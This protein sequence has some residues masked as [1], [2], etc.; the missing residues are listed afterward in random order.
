MEKLHYE[1]SYL[2]EI[3]SIISGNVKAARAR[4]GITQK[5]LAERCGVTIHAIGD[6]EA[7]RRKPSID[8]LFCLSVALGVSTP[9]LLD[10]GKE[11]IPLHTS[12]KKALEKYLVIPSDIVEELAELNPEE[13][14]LIWK[15]IRTAI[16]E[17]KAYRAKMRQEKEKKA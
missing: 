5:T 4:A 13:D 1:Y 14:A 3:T 16:D 8:L 7:G 9:D 11:P 12:P 2:M 10:S 15:N 6:I 17:E